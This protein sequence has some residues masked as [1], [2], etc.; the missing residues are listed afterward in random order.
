MICITDEQW[1]VNELKNENGENTSREEVCNLIHQ[2]GY[3]PFAVVVRPNNANEQNNDFI[4][5]RIHNLIKFL[6]L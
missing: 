4:E 1:D 2:S 3:Q 5:V 6:L